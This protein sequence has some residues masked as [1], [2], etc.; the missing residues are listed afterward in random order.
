MKISLPDVNIWLAL[1]FEGHTHH[2]S[3]RTWWAGQ[4]QSSVAM[5]RVAQMGL[6][7][8]LTNRRVLGK[9]VRTVEQAWDVERALGSDRWVIFAPEPLSLESSWAALMLQPASGTAS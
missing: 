3:A 9:A 8:L 7:R 4:R 1:A 6:L 5:C 2:P